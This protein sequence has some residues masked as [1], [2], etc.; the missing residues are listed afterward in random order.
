MVTVNNQRVYLF[1][2]YIILFVFQTSGQKFG[3]CGELLPGPEERKAIKESFLKWKNRSVDIKDISQEVTIPVVFHFMDNDAQFSVTTLESLVNRVNRAFANQGEYE[4]YYGIDSKIRFC[5]SNRTPDG[6]VSNGANLISS[7]YENFDFDL[8][9]EDFVAHISWDVTRYLNIW[10]ANSIRAEHSVLTLYD[11]KN[12]WSRPGLPAFALPGQGVVLTSLDAST[13]IHEL[14]HYLGLLHP[15]EG[16]LTE[17][18]CR[19]NDCLIDGDMVCDTPPDKNVFGPCEVNSCNTDT[20]SNYSNQI[21]FK[22]TL[23]MG[24]NF[25]DYNGCPIEFSHGQIERMHFIIEDKYPNLPIEKNEAAQCEKPCDLETIGVRVDTD[26]LIT[27]Q[28]VTFTSSGGSYDNYEWFLSR[29]INSWKSMPLPSDLVNTSKSLNYTFDNPGWYTVFLKAWNDID[30]S[31]YTSFYRNVMVTCGVDAR[32]S[33]NKR[34]N[35]SKQPHLLFTDSVT[36]TNYSIGANS[37]EWSVK[38]SDRNGETSFPE[39]KPT[40][41]HLTYLLS[42]PGEYEIQLTASNF[43]CK[44]TS[45]TLLLSVIDP[46]MDGSPVIDTIFCVNDESILV[47]V[48]LFNFGFDTIN[49]AT[50]ISFYDGDP[51]ENNGSRLL[52]SHVLPTRIFGLNELLGYA[53]DTFDFYVKANYDLLDTVFVVFNDAG[54]SSFPI[55]FPQDD[56]DVLSTSSQFPSSGLTELTYTNNYA[57]Y[58]IKIPDPYQ[59]ISACLGE[60]LIFNQNI[61]CVQTVSWSSMNQG[62]LGDSLSISYTVTGNDIIET[63]RELSTGEVQKDSFRIIVSSPKIEI[64]QEVYRIQKGEIVKLQVTAKPRDSISWS[65]I[66]SLDNAF[67]R[68]PKANPSQTTIYTVQIIDSLGCITSGEITVYVLSDGYIPNLFTPNGDGN[69]DKLFIYGLDGVEIFSFKIFNRVGNIVYYSTNAEDMI[70][71]GWDG[72]WNSTKQPSGVFYWQIS[73]RYV[74]GTP[75]R[76]N[77]AETGI[78][79]LVR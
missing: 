38:F 48:S 14:G 26:L 54:T 7:R 60:E 72:H 51:R 3:S 53:K 4:T 18:Q 34:R 21:F 1:W 17:E 78:I 62:F 10:V 70:I 44:D 45:S 49:A 16:F 75:L 50:P 64:P 22:D 32:F 55:L 24:S 30:A 25:M 77:N 74:D 37:Y 20:L 28:Q 23:D 9:L 13:L 11:G 66:S 5:L 71:N 42:E 43:T 52:E 41:E 57:F 47:K 40:D 65:P 2:I 27:G 69:N 12:W 33:P 36:F 67:I 31:C 68:S 6:G 59:D 58:N 46:T 56:K 76:L 73:G 79:H 35:A 29:G 63:S 61:S 39:F 19:N 8:E 15:F